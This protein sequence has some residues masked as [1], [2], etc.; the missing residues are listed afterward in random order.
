MKTTRKNYQISLKCLSILLLALVNPSIP[1]KSQEPLKNFLDTDIGQ[2][3]ES[4]DHEDFDCFVLTT[5]ARD[6]KDKK[7]I[8]QLL[9]VLKNPQSSKFKKCAAAFYLGELRVH[10]LRMDEA[11]DMLADNITLNLGARVQGSFTG[12]EGPV[13]YKALIRIGTPAFPSMIRNLAE[14]DEAGVRELSLQAIVQIDNDRDI[15]QLR[16]QKALKTETDAKKK[17]R[18]NVALKTLKG[19]VLP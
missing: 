9:V 14:S 7:L 16:L 11:I 6:N 18:L 8:K 13:A 1:T 4:V 3:I 2:V 17:A 10:E 5:N 19:S 12:L 15:S